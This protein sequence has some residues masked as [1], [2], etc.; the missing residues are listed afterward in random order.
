M[1]TED[2]VPRWEIHS[3][4]YPKCTSLEVTLGIFQFPQKPKMPNL[5]YLVQCRQCRLQS[6]LGASATRAVV[7]PQSNSS[8]KGFTKQT[9]FSTYTTRCIWTG[10]STVSPALGDIFVS[11][12]AP[13]LTTS[14][15]LE[16]CQ[17]LPPGVILEPDL[18][19]TSVGRVES[20]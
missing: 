9:V 12:L 10:W 3:R 14:R 18:A 15:G 5:P 19:A 4:Q 8:S 13:W 17:W 11:P 20:G 7:T 1:K 6:C 16:T 2:G